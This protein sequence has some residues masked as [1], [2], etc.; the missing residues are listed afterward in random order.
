MSEYEERMRQLREEGWC[1]VPGVIPV[2]E[3]E[4]VRDSVEA[5][6]A[7]RR[8]ADAP[9]GIGHL[10]AVV[11][12]DQCVTPYL[13]HPDV[14][15][16]V[17]G[18]LGKQIRISFTTGT[19]NYPGNPRGGWHADWPFNQRNAGHISEPYGDVPAHVTTLWMLSPF[20]A[21]NGGTLIRPGSHRL[22]HNPTG[23][24]DLDEMMEFPDECNAE[25]EAGSVLILD[26]RMWHA[27]SPNQ[28]AAPRVSVVVRYAPWWLNLEILRPG[29]P[30]RQ[31]IVDENGLRENVVP[32]MPAEVFAGMPADVQ[33]LFRHWVEKV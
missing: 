16:P 22:D 28:T 13:A 24:N 29:S 33:P 11:N 7:E 18:L 26:S 17:R 12:Y 21:A 9:P 2:G 14:I 1:V 15:G 30:E 32:D 31:M 27:S 19:I 6:V 4:A 10:T 3:V 23:D 5:T 25:G 20:T 8:R